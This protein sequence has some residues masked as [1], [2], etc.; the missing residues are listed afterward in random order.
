[1]A[2]ALGKAGRADLICWARNAFPDYCA[3]SILPHAVESGNLSFVKWLSENHSTTDL[4]WETPQLT[5]EAI[6][7]ANPAMLDFVIEKGATIS[8]YHLDIAASVSLEML[9]LMESKCTQRR[10]H[11]CF[12]AAAAGRLDVVRYL[13]TKGLF[14]KVLGAMIVGVLRC[15]DVDAARWCVEIGCEIQPLYTAV[16]SFICSQPPSKALPMASFLIAHDR[17]AFVNAFTKDAP[18]PLNFGSYRAEVLKLFIS[19]GMMTADQQRA[20]H[21]SIHNPAN[22]A[23]DTLRFLLEDLRYPLPALLF[24]EGRQVPSSYISTSAELRVHVYYVR[25]DVLRYLKELVKA[26]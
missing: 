23:L 24:D 13:H 10:P 3:N 19:L 25:R 16:C 15:C 18:I 20:L 7:S 5:Q 4:R 12:T 8:P 2:P 6:R 14:R 17:S 22:Y 1:M 11:A 9:K 21:S 26:V